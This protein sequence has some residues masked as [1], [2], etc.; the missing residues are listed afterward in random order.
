MTY[1]VGDYVRLVSVK[2]LQGKHI[3]QLQDLGVVEHLYPHSGCFYVCFARCV[4]V[5]SEAML[6]PAWLVHLEINPLVGAEATARRSVGDSGWGVKARCQELR[7]LLD[8][9][10]A[11]VG[12]RSIG[13]YDTEHTG[14]VT[15]LWRES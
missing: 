14:A 15:G 5:C 1:K 2:E 13:Y 11:H 9:L 6:E 10:A 7:F 8:N 12:W 3:T 4:V